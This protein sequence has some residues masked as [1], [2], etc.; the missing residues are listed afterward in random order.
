MFYVAAPSSITLFLALFKF[1]PYGIDLIPLTSTLSSILFLFVLFKYDFLEIIPIARDKIFESLVDGVIVLDKSYIIVDFNPMSTNIFPI[2]N[3]DIRGLEIKSILNEF[4][5]V[6]DSLYKQKQ[7]KLNIINN[8]NELSF[9]ETNTYP[10]KDK[11]NKELGFVI[12]IR[13]I[14]QQEISIQK[15]RQLA[16]VDYLTNTYNRRYFY[17]IGEN[18]F[19]KAIRY[20]HPFSI[21]LFDIDYFKKINDTHGHD[22]GDKVLIQI[23][24]I[25][26]QLV[27][28]T[29]LLARYGGEEFIAFL[30]ETSGD[31]ALTLAERLRSKIELHKFEPDSI[32]QITISI[33]ISKF[34]T[35]TN[36]TLDSIIKKADEALYLAKNR[37]RNC[38][39]IED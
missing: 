9:Y 26:K 19:N 17:E 35:F 27:R 4:P 16:S 37:G 28:K 3:N 18:E 20:N 34:E 5:E 11:F 10:L 24:D 36:Q 13:N 22:I 29:D 8:R 32:T 2:L 6:I 12:L 31:Q 15:L 1:I 14:T 7:S 39:V 21:I 30:P 33:G 25:C 38:V 23:A